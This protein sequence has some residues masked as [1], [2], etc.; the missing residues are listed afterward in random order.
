MTIEQ[1]AI[2]YA[3]S[4]SKNETYQKYLVNAFL[5]GAESQ[6]ATIA[7]QTTEEVADQRKTPSKQ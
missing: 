3:K 2:E 6:Y 4:I 1:K 5:E 7:P